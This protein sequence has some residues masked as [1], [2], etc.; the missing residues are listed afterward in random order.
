MKPTLQVDLTRY[1]AVGSTRGKQYGIA[2]LRSEQSEVWINAIHCYQRR[3]LEASDNDGPVSRKS[4]GEHDRLHQ[5]FG[6]QTTRP[7]FKLY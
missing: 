7:I 6:E 5:A 4:S 2:V 3:A 1:L